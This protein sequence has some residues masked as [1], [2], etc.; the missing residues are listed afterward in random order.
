MLLFDYDS[1]STIGSWIVYALISAAFVIAVAFVVY[2]IFYHKIVI[3]G[4]NRIREK[5]NRRKKG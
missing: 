2:F 5:M 1:I 3:R 4:F